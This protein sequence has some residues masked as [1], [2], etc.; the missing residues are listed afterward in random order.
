MPPPRRRSHFFGPASLIPIFLALVVSLIGFLPSTNETAFPPGST[1][2]LTAHPDDEAM[3]F[4]PAVQSLGNKRDVWAVCMSTGN[5]DNLGLI[6]KDELSNS[7]E[8]LGIDS[9]KL[10]VFD[11]PDLQDGMRTIWSPSLIAS[12]IQPII[13]EN[14]ISIILTFDSHG[15]S[16]HPNH[17]ALSRAALLLRPP[18]S[19]SLSP[20]PINRLKTYYLLTQPTPLKYLSFF[21]SL[22]QTLTTQATPQTDGVRSSEV[23]L[24]GDEGEE[25]RV[26]R[27]NVGWEGY[28]KGVSAMLEHGSQMRWFRWG[29]VGTSRYMW[30]G[31]WVLIE[32]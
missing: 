7:Y 10:K 29:Y 17:I 32:G 23:V 24:K 27:A 20:S 16:H 12:L 15:I 2:I 26:V 3:F 22:F 5:A 31:E 9:S 13:D 21:P 4:A 19:P 28:W 6:R 1:L 18:S 14:N 25:V 11:H 30:G 8:I